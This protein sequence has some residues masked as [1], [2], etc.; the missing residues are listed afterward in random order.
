M[1]AGRLWIREEC[2]PHCTMEV[3]LRAGLFVAKASAGGP[4]WLRRHRCRRHE[5]QG[6]C[7]DESL[8]ASSYLSS[9]SF[10]SSG[11]D[12]AYSP[13]QVVLLAA[14][15]GPDRER[16]E[17][18]QRQRV[19]QRLVRAVAQITLAQNL[20]ADNSLPG[21]AHFAHQ[22]KDGLRFGGRTLSNG[23]HV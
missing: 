7:R 9:S 18:V 3:C 20:H 21:G 16:V 19:F 8:H 5:E 6:H 1:L 13:D 2:D 4:F 14:A 22:R 10:C 23:V 15:L 12:E 17:E 11:P